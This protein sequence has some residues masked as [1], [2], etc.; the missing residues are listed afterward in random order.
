MTDSK[1][2]SEIKVYTNHNLSRLKT[3]QAE[4]NPPQIVS[5]SESSMTGSWP[6]R[7]DEAEKFLLTV[8]LPAYSGYAPSLRTK[9]PKPLDTVPEEETREDD[10]KK[11]DK[12]QDPNGKETSTSP[13]KPALVPE[14]QPQ[15]ALID[16]DSS[17]SGVPGPAHTAKIQAQP[18]E[19]DLLVFGK[20]SVVSVMLGPTAEE[21]LQAPSLRSPTVGVQ[22]QGHG[23]ELLT[24]EEENRPSSGSDQ[25]SEYF[26]APSEVLEKDGGA[27]GVPTVAEEER[28]QDHESDLPAFGSQP[29]LL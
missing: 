26:D 9:P 18:D 13:T 16:F 28:G 10:T 21:P 4:R 7:W 23:L 8:H 3:F 5:P 17:D 29:S 1:K 20:G 14:Q 24:F 12:R 11:T 19:P 2:G 15:Q 6:V 27:P 22:G 25:M